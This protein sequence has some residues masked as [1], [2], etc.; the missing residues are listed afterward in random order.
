MM[1][2]RNLTSHRARGYILGAISAIT[3]GINPLCALPLYDSGL[4]VSSVLC[5]RYVT[6]VVLL[7]LLMIY[8]RESFAIE[9]KDLPH[10]IIAGLLFAFS[11]LFLFESYNHMDVGIASTLLF[12]YPIIVTIIMVT[13]YHEKISILTIISILVAI[14]GIAL[15]YRTEGNGTLSTIGI[16]CVVASSLSYALYM[17][18]VNKSRLQYFSTIKLSFYAL[19]FGLSVFVVKLDFL[20]DIDPMQPLLV[21]WLCLIGLSVFPTII[22]L[23]TMTIA[24][25]DIGS[26]PVSILG[27]L[28][29]LT[30]LIFGIFVFGEKITPTNGLGILLIIAAVTL[31][32]VAKP[33]IHWFCKR[34]K[35]HRVT[36]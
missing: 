1:K 14:L 27:A 15:L 25:H 29:P 9:L 22:S 20:T 7:A 17:V 13:V 33:L 10:L 30:A 5:Y 31:I 26:I 11:S 34:V 8:R 21:P 18:L 35:N 24:I 36:N 3:Y 6:A 16:L 2:N 32:V 12:V 4:S 19:L 23:V 28:E